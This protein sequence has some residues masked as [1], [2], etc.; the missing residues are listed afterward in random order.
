MT[1]TVDAPGPDSM[2]VNLPGYEFRINAIVT[3]FVTQKK[4]QAVR[5]ARG[6]RP[7]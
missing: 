3:I 7:A 4:H 6:D 1:R 5:R 2:E